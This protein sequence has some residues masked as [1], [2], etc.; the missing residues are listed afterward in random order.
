MVVSTTVASLVVR[1]TATVVRRGRV[2]LQG[3]FFRQRAG[4]VWRK[5]WELWE[6]TEIS[7]S[8]LQVEQRVISSNSKE[9]SQGLVGESK[10]SRGRSVAL[11]LWFVRL[12]SSVV[13]V[14]LGEPASFV[15]AE[16][17]SCCF[18]REESTRRLVLLL[19]RERRSSLSLL[20][21]TP[22]RRSLATTRVAP[23]TSDLRLRWKQRMSRDHIAQPKLSASCRDTPRQSYQ[24]LVCNNDGTSK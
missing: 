15:A 20:L 9:V 11:F 21:C 16:Q 8:Q 1:L 14:V 22:T 23:P 6:Q 24:V 5:G 4:S 3:V 19:V 18:L 7:Q 12:L 17:N 10:W 13:V 2:L